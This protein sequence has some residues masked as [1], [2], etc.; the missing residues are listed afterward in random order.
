MLLHLD[1]KKHQ[2]W[3]LLDTRCSIGLLNNQTMERLDIP[4]EKHKRVHIIE[5]YTGESVQGAG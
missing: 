2:I 5:S 3:M 4:K 1:G